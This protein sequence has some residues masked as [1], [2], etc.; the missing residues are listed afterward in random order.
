M[1]VLPTIHSFAGVKDEDE[2]LQ[3]ICDILESLPYGITIESRLDNLGGCY[4]TGFY[5]QKLIRIEKGGG[6]L[7]QDMTGED[8]LEEGYLYK[9]PM[10]AVAWLICKLGY[11]NNSLNFESN[12]VQVEDGN[13]ELA[14]RLA[15]EYQ[16]NT[17]LYENLG[18]IGFGVKSNARKGF[19][20][21]LISQLSLNH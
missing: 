6:L 15:F 7:V 13:S 18:S 17:S 11:G 4:A 12:L 21:C 14:V 8:S 10:M 3:V 20:A 9:N 2:A 19:G 1:T 5:K 16:P